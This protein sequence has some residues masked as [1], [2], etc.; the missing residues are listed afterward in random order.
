MN[1]LSLVKLIGQLLD[2]RH[3]LGDLRIPLSNLCVAL[4]QRCLQGDNSSIA[5]PLIIRCN[6]GGHTKLRS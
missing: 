4:S 1:S 5:A 3:E 6:A 2:L